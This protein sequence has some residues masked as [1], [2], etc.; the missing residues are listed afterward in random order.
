MADLIYRGALS[1]FEVDRCL[2]QRSAIGAGKVHFAA[3]S[4]GHY[5]GRTINPDMIPRVSSL[6]YFDILEEQD[7]GMEEHRNEGLEICF[8]ETGSSELVVEGEVHRMLPGDVSVTR[9]WQLHRIGNPNLHPG[10]LHWVI[11]DLQT[12]RPNQAWCWPEWCILTAADKQTLTTLLRG[13]ENPVW[14]AGAEMLQLFRKLGEHVQSLEVE[15]AASR[16]RVILNRLLIGL[17]ELLQGQEI[18]IDP[19]LSS[20]SRTVELFLKELRRSATVRRLPWSLDSMAEHCG[21]GR[22]SFADHCHLLTNRTPVDYLNHC[23][24]E[25]AAVRLRERPDETVSQIADASGFNSLSYFARKFRAQFGSSPTEWR[26]LGK[27]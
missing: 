16:I 25:H 3:L 23:R 2:P 14:N 9:P 15:S 27:R 19:R 20:R 10:R 18:G 26:E 21:I 24:M 12:H 8:Q 5:P 6:G 4:S 7:W 11:I 17:L 22:T 1:Q 13:N